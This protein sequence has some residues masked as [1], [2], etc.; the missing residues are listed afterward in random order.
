MENRSD[1]L[2]Q[3]LMNEGYNELIT[4][5]LVNRGYDEEI[6]S[7]LLNTGYSEE[8][9]DYNNITN[10]QTGADIIESH[11][12][13][14]SD[15]YIFGDYDSDGVNSAYILGDA[16][17]HAIYVSDSESTINIK[18]PERSEGYGLNMN[19][20]KNL[21]ANKAKDIL[22]ITVDNGIAQDKEVAYLLD[23][24]IDV[25]ITDH[26]A[27]N[28][29]TPQNVFIIDAFYNNDSI[30]N[31]GLCG[32]GVA[33]K[34][35]MTLLERYDIEN[36]TEL[37]YKYIIHVAIATITDSMPMTLDNIKYVYNGL[38]LLK[39][40]YGSEA[41][42]YYKEYNNNTDLT[43]KDIA[44]GLGPQ[45][46]SCGRMNN[47]LLAL[48]YLFATDDDI[49][50]L[51]NEISQMNDRRK[52]KTKKAI[53]IAEEMIDLDKETIILELDDVEGIAGIIASNLSSKYNK[54]TIIF[55]R[56][57]DVLIGSA[58]SDG[59]VDF[60]Q[61]LKII[62]ESNDS[63]I[64]LGGHAGACGI[65]IKAD[66]MKELESSLENFLSAIPKIK[67]EPVKTEIVVDDYITLS[68]VTK[69]NCDAL[70]S[71]YFFTE[72]NPVFA[73]NDVIITKVKYSGNNPNNVCFDLKDNSGTLQ[74]WTWG[75]GDMYRLLKE[76]KQVSL[77]AELDMK[78]GKPSL[79]II[80]IIPK[81]EIEI[82]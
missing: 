31:K 46:N 65:T 8:L 15:V 13:N 48:N 56:A 12:A 40:G 37:Y 75:I 80:S 77:I 36:F 9:P 24:G 78:F 51:Y 57:G 45:I 28:G 7:A 67:I 64:K 71:L 22:V 69:K 18:L 25:L 55:S 30:D 43:P 62:A 63:I 26:H 10:I 79:N 35:A 4:K 70:R 52:N 2:T 38:Q 58:R 23:N 72:T 21:V 60:L 29:H 50:D 6:I 41:I 53:E 42:N 20:C 3:S 34:L 81:R 68:D 49:E 32:A 16:I 61:T 47:T 39:D 82:C 33:F 76:P 14:G 1:E 59:H 66:G 19:W 74:T 73:I 11:L 44:F 27:P 17:S 54:C 5:V